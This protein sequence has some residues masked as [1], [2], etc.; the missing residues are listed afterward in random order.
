[1]ISSHYRKDGAILLYALSTTAGPQLVQS[2]AGAA[3]PPR[4]LRWLPNVTAAGAVGDPSILSL[5]RDNVVRVW[6]PSA[7]AIE[8]R[9][10]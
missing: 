7:Q 9:A 8:V 4:V 2:F 3:E 1:M 6:H 10:Q 5:G